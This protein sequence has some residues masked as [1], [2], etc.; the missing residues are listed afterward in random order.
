ENILR[1]YVY[2]SQPMAEGDFLKHIRLEHVA[3][4]TDLT[5]VF[6]DNIYELWSAD[7]KRITLLVDPGRVKLGL[8]ANIA[9]GRAF[10]AGEEYRL[11]VRA[12][13]KTIDGR[14]LNESFTKTFRAGGEDRVRVDPRTWTL[15]LPRPGTREAL[16]VD[17]G[18][19]VDHVSVGHFLRVVSAR[20]EALP[21]TWQLMPDER[22]ARWTPAQAWTAVVEEHRLVVDRRFEDIAGNNVD[23]A[24][25]H[26]V[27][28]LDSRVDKR[29]II[30]P[31]R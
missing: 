5:G 20:D 21:G 9:Q 10:R 28:E 11:H 30:R 2:F 25:D 14:A 17:F 13:W 7:R 4:G 3:S 26:R 12:S 19:P 18:E 6:F 31:F 1:F 29:A 22:R 15:S 16:V 8:Q 24:L 27:G 23:A